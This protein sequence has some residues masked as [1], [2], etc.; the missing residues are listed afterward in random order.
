LNND[1]IDLYT[2]TYFSLIY[3]IQFEIENLEI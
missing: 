1:S 3:F 2:F